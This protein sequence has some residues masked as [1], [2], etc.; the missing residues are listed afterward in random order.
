MKSETLNSED[1]RKAISIQDACNLS[2]VVHSFSDV[3][4]KIWTEARCLGEGTD[5]VNRHPISVLYSNKI[6][7][8]ADPDSKIE[9]YS[10]AYEICKSEA[11]Q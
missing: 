11:D 9:N 8:L 5:W 1:Y 2:G 4:S 7:S 3:I 6:N 10:R